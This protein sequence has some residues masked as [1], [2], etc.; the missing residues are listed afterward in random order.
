MAW[1]EQ[2][3]GEPGTTTVIPGGVCQPTI[4]EK[5]GLQNPISP[6]WSPRPCGHGTEAGNKTLAV[7]ARAACGILQRLAHW[8]PDISMTLTP[9]S[10]PGSIPLN[11]RLS[12]HFNCVECDAALLG[13]APGNGWGTWWTVGRSSLCLLRHPEDRAK[14]MAQKRPSLIL[15]QWRTVPYYMYSCTMPLWFGHYMMN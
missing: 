8:R 7:K 3:P 10:A 11:K 14:L 13:M 5:A 9:G 15:H 1:R 4:N 2:W 6:G 12:R